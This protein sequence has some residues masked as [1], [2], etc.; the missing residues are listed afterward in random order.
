MTSDETGKICVYDLRMWELSR[1]IFDSK[2]KNDA[3]K[4]VSSWEGSGKAEI[5]K[6]VQV[7]AEGWVCAVTEPGHLYTWDP[8]RD[9]EMTKQPTMIKATSLTTSRITR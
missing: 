7:S 5:F 6:D 4:A 3:R 9:W 1:V 2:M 8:C